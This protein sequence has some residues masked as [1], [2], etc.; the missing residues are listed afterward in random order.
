MLDVDE[1]SASMFESVEA[2]AAADRNNICPRTFQGFR[3]DISTCIDRRA[4]SYDNALLAINT[5]A[6]QLTSLLDLIMGGGGEKTPGQLVRPF[7]RS[8]ALRNCRHE[9]LFSL[10]ANANFLRADI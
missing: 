10:N 9:K 7:V 4:G 8:S 1:S 6:C 3:D 5:D 2:S